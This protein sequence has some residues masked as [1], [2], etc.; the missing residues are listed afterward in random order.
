M[1]KWRSKAQN[2]PKPNPD[3]ILSEE[4]LERIESDPEF[5]RMMKE[6]EEDIRAGR[7]ITHEEA[8]RRLH[9]GGCS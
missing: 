3:E 4:D 5:R 2:A 9:A 1:S 8:M 7:F 6:S